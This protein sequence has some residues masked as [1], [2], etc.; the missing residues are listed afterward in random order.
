MHRFFLRLHSQQLKVPFRTFILV[1]A[2]CSG[3]AF[4]EIILIEA[5]MMMMISQHP[6][7]VPRDQP[8]SGVKAVLAFLCCG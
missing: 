5:V 7:Y 4:S 6:G 1:A 8:S 2:R 3:L